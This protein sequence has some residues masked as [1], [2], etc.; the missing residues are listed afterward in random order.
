MKLTHPLEGGITCACTNVEDAHI[1]VL[2]LNPLH[3][4]SDGCLPGSLRG[5]LLSVTQAFRLQPV[6]DSAHRRLDWNRARVLSR[7]Q[8]VTAWHTLGS[9]ASCA[10]CPGVFCARQHE[11]AFFASADTHVTSAARACR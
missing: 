4:S 10:T 6:S 5:G 11:A 1:L 7:S 9:C 3:G 8:N 2:R